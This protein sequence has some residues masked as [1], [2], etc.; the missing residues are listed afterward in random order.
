MAKDIKCDDLRILSQFTMHNIRK[1]RVC[2]VSLLLHLIP[3]MNVLSVLYETFGNFISYITIV[4][5]LVK[6]FNDF[7]NM[8]INLKIY[9][10]NYKRFKN[11]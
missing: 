2:Y 1:Y 10:N 6:F 3:F 8:E 9:M 7:E 5:K 4:I 11:T